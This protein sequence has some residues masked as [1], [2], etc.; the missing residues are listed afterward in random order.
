MRDIFSLE[1]GKDGNKKRRNHAQ[2]YIDKLFQRLES[3]SNAGHFQRLKREESDGSQVISLV[4]SSFYS[5]Y[6][7]IVLSNGKCI[8]DELVNDPAHV[9]PRTGKM[10]YADASKLFIGKVADQFPKASREGVRSYLSNLQDR[11]QISGQKYDIA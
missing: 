7:L 11:V 3:L 6:S 1:A 9:G 8:V 2:T 4:S 10:S 5:K